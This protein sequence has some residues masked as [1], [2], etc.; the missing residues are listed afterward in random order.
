MVFL[1][2]YS[3]GFFLIAKAGNLNGKDMTYLLLAGLTFASMIMVQMNMTNIMLPMI[4]S[5]TG[6]VYAVRGR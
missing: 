6:I 5:I 3:G 1:G 2:I 4:L